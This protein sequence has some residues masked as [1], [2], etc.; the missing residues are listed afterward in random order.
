MAVR[1]DLLS[2]V[3]HV[4]T[5]TSDG[6]FRPPAQHAG[7]ALVRSLGGQGPLRVVSQVH[8]ARV[9]EASAADGHTEADAIVSAEPGAVVAVRV[10]DCVPI[11]MAAGPV[12]GVRAVAAVHAGWRGTAA[13][14]ARI[15]LRQLCAASGCGPDAVRAA[16]GPAIC[17]TC[18]EVGTEVHE[19]VSRLVPDGVPPVPAGARPHVDL[20]A[21][22]AA[23]LRAEGVRVEVLRDCTRCSPG[24]WSHRR[25]GAAGG[26]QVGAIRL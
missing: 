15:A 9:V 12:G 26:R 7:P 3:P 20:R 16:I 8:G 14:I 6:D 25:D 4:F 18:Y 17:G 21:A 13:D 2:D 1:A 19:A 11:L 5:G 23:L 22:N 10:A 24:Y